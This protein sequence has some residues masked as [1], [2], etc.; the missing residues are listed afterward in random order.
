MTTKKKILLSVVITALVTGAVT[1]VVK[2]LGYM[3]ISDAGAIEKLESKL[4]MINTYLD[5]SYIYDYDKEAMAEMAVMGYVEG[6]DEPYTHYYDKA[7]FE[8]YMET[9][10][11]DYVGIGAVISVTEN[12]ELIIISTYEDSGSFEAGI[13]P[14]DIIVAVEGTPYN[15]DQMEEAV[16]HIKNGGEGTTVTIS[17]KRD[18]EQIEK[19]VERRRVSTQSVKTQMLDNNIGYVRLSAFNSANE[20]SDTDSYTEFKENVEK[21]RGEGMEKM[22]ID[23]RDNPGGALDVV[24]NIADYLLPEGIITYM[25]YKDGSREDFNSDAEELG[26]PMVV[27]INEN[28]ASASEVLTGALKDYKKATVVGMK[29]YGKGVVQSVLPFMDGSG[30]SLT[31]AKYFSPNGVCI[32]G[33]GIEPDIAVEMPEEY[34]NMYASQVERE[35]DV[36]LQKAIEVLNN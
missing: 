12:D 34:K 14:G 35:N 4:K 26:I 27:L 28:S 29:S 13:L 7:S 31:I 10:S 9:M 3:M 2:D 17:L 15:G 16:S 33:T 21:L 36:Q 30:M 5:T 6:L 22:I 11:E 1:S 25:E 20:G 32:H 8:N 18:G 23:L 19:T 24:C